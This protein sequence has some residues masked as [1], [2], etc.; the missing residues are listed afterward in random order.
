MCEYF[1]YTPQL[2]ILTFDKCGV[3]YVQSVMSIE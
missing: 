3:K 2:N 1:L